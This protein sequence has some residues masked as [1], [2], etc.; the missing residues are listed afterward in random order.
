VNDDLL[1][2][3][4]PDTSPQCVRFNVDLTKVKD[5]LITHSHQDHLYMQD[6]RHRKK[7]SRQDGSLGMMTVWGNPDSIDMFHEQMRDVLIEIFGERKNIVQPT[8]EEVIEELGEY[9]LMQTRVIQPHQALNVGRYRVHTIHAHHKEPEL[10]LNFIIDD[11]KK[12]ILYGTDTGIWE[13]AEWAFIESLGIK[14]DLVAL[15]CT[16]GT[17]PGGGGHHSNESFLNTKDEFVSRGLLSPGARFFAHHFSHQWNIVYDDIVAFMAPHGV[18]VTYDGLV[19][20]I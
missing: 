16:V 14:M 8:R 2:D 19:V 15:D 4:G 3:Y 1:V 9:L 20:E 13:R 5:A 11:G 10:S 7:D 17:K 6:V 18:E 12:R